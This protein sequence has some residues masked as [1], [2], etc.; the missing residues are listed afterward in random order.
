MGGKGGAG[1]TGCMLALAEWFEANRIPFTLLDLD[2]E[3]KARGSFKHY[4]NGAARKVNIHTPAGLDAFIDHLA[5]GAPIILAD[6]GAGSGQVAQAWFD[7]MYEDVAKQ[8]IAFTAIGIITSDP[9]SVE[10]VLSWANRL[11]DRV[12][13]LIVENAATPYADLAY[14]Q[15]SEQA[16]R[17]REMFQP[18]VIAMEFRLA[19]R[20]NPARQHGVTLGQV[21]E[22]KTQVEELQ[23]ASIVMRAQAYRRQLFA[24]IR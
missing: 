7:T 21:A 16:Q 22:R 11:R 18:G 13:Y 19:D 14:W 8:G 4:F 3:N 6:M 9:A 17:F 24:E 5:A 23:K 15:S 1:K 20:E 12:D 10:S 2:T